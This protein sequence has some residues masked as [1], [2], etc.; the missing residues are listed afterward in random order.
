MVLLCLEGPSAVGKSTTCKRLAEQYS[1]YIVP[2]VNEL[3]ERPTPEPTY[4]YLERQVERWAIAQSKL[5]TYEIV[6]FDGD[7]FQPLW[8]NWCF[9]F[10]N[11]QP[12]SALRDFYRQQIIEQGIGFPDGYILLCTNEAD[13]HRR[14]EN[15]I[16]RK[17]SG[18][19]KH[20]QIIEPQQRYFQAINNRF[21]G[22]VRL[23]E[24]TSVEDNVKNIINALPSFSKLPEPPYSLPVFDSLIEWLNTNKA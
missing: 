21:P 2:E 5:K 10:V 8:Y 15:D 4:W 7:V 3:F 19:A 23:I 22:Y 14:K 20:L 9:D 12:L 13:L 6:V 18:F 11:W 1:A 16:T 24:T 17:R